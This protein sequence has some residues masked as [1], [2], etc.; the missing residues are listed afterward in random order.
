MVINCHLARIHNST[1]HQ[2]REK[3]MSK[4]K[5]FLVFSALLTGTLLTIGCTVGT[6]SATESA[7]IDPPQTDYSDEASLEEVLQM[8]ENEEDEQDQEGL[9][10]VEETQTNGDEVVTEETGELISR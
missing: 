5:R 6:D 1:N 2:R 7:P 8:F 10:E 3:R 9:Q 4:F